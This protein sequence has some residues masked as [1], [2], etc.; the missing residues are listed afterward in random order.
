MALCL[1][2]RYHYLTLPGRTA[3]SVHM[4]FSFD[5]S[6][7]WKGLQSNNGFSFGREIRQK[8]CSCEVQPILKLTY[9][10]F[11][12][13]EKFCNLLWFVVRA[14]ATRIANSRDW[15]R[16]T[17]RAFG[18]CRKRKLE[19]HRDWFKPACYVLLPFVCHTSLC[20]P[21]TGFPKWNVILGNDYL[22]YS[23]LH[24]K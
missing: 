19:R 24:K 4:T 23:L 17:W 2:N 11:L 15:C 6:C 3:C 1:V 21:P 13:I 9:C 20:L 5:W 14:H 12:M 8:L 10:K 16:S 18:K 7:P 22:N